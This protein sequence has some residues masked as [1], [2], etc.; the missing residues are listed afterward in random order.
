[1]LVKISVNCQK[2]GKKLKAPPSLAGK[3]AKCSQC[4]SIVQIPMPQ[5]DSGE[6]GFELQAIDEPVTKPVKPVKAPPVEEK[7]FDPDTGPLDLLDDLLEPELPASALVAHTPDA[8]GSPSKGRGRGRG[9]AAAGDPSAADHDLTSMLDRA[10]A[11]AGKRGYD[12]APQPWFSLMGVDFTPV[13]SIVLLVVI[14][15][16]LG[17]SIWYFTGP[18]QGVRI[19]E[20]QPVTA[21]IAMNSLGRADAKGM[22]GMT[23]GQQGVKP[24]VSPLGTQFPEQSYGLGGPDRLIFTRPDPNGDY[25]L[26]HVKISQR[27]VADE[28]LESRYD[29]MFTAGNFILHA[30]NEQI[31]PMLIMGK[32]PND[33]LVFNTDSAKVDAVQSMLP[34]GVNPDEYQDLVG[35]EQDIARATLLYNGKAG[36]TGKVSV[37]SKRKLFDQPGVT[38]VTGNGELVQKDPY[39]GMSLKYNYQGGSMEVSWAG[40]AAAWWSSDQYTMAAAVSPFSRYDIYLLY[41][42][43]Q[44]TSNMVVKVNNRIVGTLASSMAAKPGQTP[45]TIAVAGVPATPTNLTVNLN[46]N[47]PTTPEEAAKA[48]A[49]GAGGTGGKPAATPANG[50]KPDPG[51][52]DYFGAL[53]R[54][55]DMGKGVIADNNMKQLGLGVIMYAQQNKGDL[56]PNIDYLRKTMGDINA[57]LQNVRTN[58]NPGFLYIQ[59]APNLSAVT[60]PGATPF[61]YE[62]RD[63]KLDRD[64]AIMYLDGHIEL[65]KK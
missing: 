3:R 4:G 10:A 5:D 11:N 23:M 27:V 42:R 35:T 47:T 57:L 60:N 32:L 28:H 44:T 36:V 62:L 25:L 43:P 53:A 29:A 22:A 20:A 34:T 54:A 30:G 56:P 8:Q 16:L 21:L 33:P 13:K 17:S 6:T 46:P 19:Y 39:S 15:S 37:S 50:K 9:K 65:P 41:K 58:S 64:G 40:P 1:M 63:G 24:P 31:T 2:C 48:L 59:P 49:G 12:N 7:T 55:R 51:M 14:L 45:S 26:V 61:L 18:G 52:F 38:G